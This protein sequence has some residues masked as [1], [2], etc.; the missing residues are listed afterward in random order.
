MAGRIALVGGDEFRPTC[1]E[2]DA[3]LLLATGKSR[4]RLLVVPTAAS[5]E[6]AG[7]AANHGVTHFLDLGADAAPLMVTTS[8][9][10]SAIRPGSEYRYLL[11]WAN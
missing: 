7:L 10:A 3:E 6:N 5:H 8:Q 4:P 1:R 2:M 9:H 11:R